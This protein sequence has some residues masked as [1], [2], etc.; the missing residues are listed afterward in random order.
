MK[1]RTKAVT[2][3]AIIAL[4]IG[5]AFLVPVFYWFTGISPSHEL[6]G[7]ST[8]IYTAYRS[9]GCEFLGF[10]DEYFGAP[11]TIAPI[12]TPTYGATTNGIV[13]SC[14]APDQIQ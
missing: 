11:V 6:G 8:P 12:G 1:R 5:F 10:G 3:A 2:G 9:L 4:S 13:F 14:A 7:S